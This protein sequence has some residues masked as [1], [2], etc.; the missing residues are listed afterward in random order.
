MRSDGSKEGI[1]SWSAGASVPWGA[2]YRC[3]RALV[4]DVTGKHLTPGIVDAHS[5][6]AIA[7]G[8][9]E[10]SH[11]VTSEVRIADVIDPT[12]INLYRQLAGE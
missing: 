6:T 10:A 3:R 2:G 12:D 7:G 9:N 11:A 5:H 8:L 4:L 1:C